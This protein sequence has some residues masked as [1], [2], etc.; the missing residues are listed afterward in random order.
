MPCMAIGTCTEMKFSTKKWLHTRVLLILVVL[1]ITGV[2]VYSLVAVSYTH[3]DVYK[4]QF[5]YV[6]GKLSK[7]TDSTGSVNV[8]MINNAI[9]FL[10]EEI[11]YELA[12]VEVDRTK[13]DGIC[14]LYTSRC[15]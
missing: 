12:G 1:V 11:R 15:V 14:L 3:L 6:E 9:A 8:K 7:K 13:S 4:R 2:L 5:L 10:F